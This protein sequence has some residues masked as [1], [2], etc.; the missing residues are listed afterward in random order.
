MNKKSEILIYNLPDGSSNV[1]VLLNED[2]IW[3]NKDALVNLYQTSRQNIE[4]HIK[5]IYEEGELDINRTCNKKLQVQTEG[6][7]YDFKS[8]YRIIKNIPI[9]FKYSKRMFCYVTFFYNYF[10]IK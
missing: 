10:I 2:D 3:M 8:M 7:R 6:K 4:K 1:E 9:E 5:H